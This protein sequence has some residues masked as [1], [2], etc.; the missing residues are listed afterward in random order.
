M[1]IIAADLFYALT[2]AVLILL[3]FTAVSN[4]GDPQIFGVFAAVFLGVLFVSISADIIMN[5][6]IIRSITSDNKYKETLKLLE[7][8]EISDGDIYYYFNRSF[9]DNI[10]YGNLQASEEDYRRALDT[11][12]LPER[13][14]SGDED[15]LS[16]SD[17]Q[18]AVLAR[19][20]LSNPEILDISEILTRCDS[21]TKRK[22]YV[23]I[24]I[25]YPEI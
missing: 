9:R 1:L 23:N 16:D 25:N 14:L 7:S 11:I 5:A 13:P 3:A 22:I 6:L 15:Y 24:K 8:G 2:S 12:N 4:V 20:L 18:K 21:I 19:M 17:K 10:M